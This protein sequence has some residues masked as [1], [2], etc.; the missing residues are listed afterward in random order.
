MHH[1]VVLYA[2]PIPVGHRVELRWYEQVST[3][4]LGG[5]N[6]TA[7]EHEP[8]LVDLDTG[9]EYASDHAYGQT[10]SMKRPDQPITVASQPVGEPVQILTGRVKACR[11]IHVRRYRD[12]DV[13]TDLLIDPAG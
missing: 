12:I 10:D 5:K 11:V 13:Q 1:I 7:R 4:L 3:G 8:V 6:E 2:A 9:I